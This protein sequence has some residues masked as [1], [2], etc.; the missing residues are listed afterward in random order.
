M[1]TINRKKEKELTSSA[2]PANALHT[3]LFGFFTSV[4]C[5]FFGRE[6][7]FFYPFSCKYA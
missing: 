3:V 2:E 6:K 5:R 7:A 4:G 1:D